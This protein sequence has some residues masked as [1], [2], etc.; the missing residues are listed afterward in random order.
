MVIHV[1]TVR[2]IWM[3]SVLPTPADTLRTNQELLSDAVAIT[4]H[5]ARVKAA[6]TLATQEEFAAQEIIEQRR[7]DMSFGDDERSRSQEH[8]HWLKAAQYRWLELAPRHRRM[9][10]NNIEFHRFL[11]FKFL[12]L[13]DTRW[14]ID[15]LAADNPTAM[16]EAEWLMLDDLMSDIRGSLLRMERSGMLSERLDVIA[17]FQAIEHTLAQCQT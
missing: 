9:A 7:L 15:T 17:S 12:K 10:Y 16:Q 6:P 3:G 2:S 11:A 1:R 8:T 14:L 4:P 5:R 13:S